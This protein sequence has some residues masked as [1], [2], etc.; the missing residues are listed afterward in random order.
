M[1]IKDYSIILDDAAKTA[2]S[3][4]QI[5]N[6]T[7]INLDDAYT[8]QALSMKR[9]YRRGEKLV[10]LKMGFTSKAKMEQMGVHDLIWGRLT[11]AMEIEVDG[12]MPSKNFIHPRAEPELAF[13]L[14][15]DIKIPISLDE[16][17]SVI[18]GIAPAIEII[19]SRYRNFKF[20]L[21]DVIA[22]NCSS[23]GYA[24]GKWHAPNTDVSNLSIDIGINGTISKSGN[25]N[26]ILGNPLQSLVEAS[27][28]ALV[29]GQELKK[30]MIVLAGAATPAIHIK[31]GETVHASFGILG[32]LKFNVV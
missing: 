28:L 23:S 22:D 16:I 20:S 31:K 12:D 14:K 11:D 25:S 29:Y 27:R 8:I 4:S 30:D 10:G 18:G 2:T 17:G 9:R 5:S 6:T 3:I 26:A 21:E 7:K 13:L 15:K 24:I 19:D 32:E 1:N